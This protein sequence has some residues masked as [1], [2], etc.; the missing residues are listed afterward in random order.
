MIEL[1]ELAKVY[2]MGTQE[3]HAL[4]GASLTILD[5]EFLAIM[6]PSGSGKS[7]LMNMIGCLDQPSSGRYLLDGVDI[8]HMSDDELAAMINRVGYD[9]SGRKF[10]IRS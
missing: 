5:S 7:T 6:G 10:S 9:E 1:H 3:V 2:Q 4:R 8:S